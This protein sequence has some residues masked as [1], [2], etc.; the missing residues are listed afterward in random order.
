ML[1]IM[2]VNANGLAI[3]RTEGVETRDAAEALRGATLYVIRDSLPEPDEGEFY[4]ADLLG[5][6]VK[7]QDGAELGSLVAIHDF[8][9]GEIAELASREGPT[10]MVPFG[11]DRIVAVD[12]VAKELRLIVPDGLLDDANVGDETNVDKIG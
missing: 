10:I 7:G 4:H 11:G 8:G 2:S 6:A 9:A 3:V 1:Q 5:I 12:M